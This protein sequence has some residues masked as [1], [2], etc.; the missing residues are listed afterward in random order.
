MRQ[1]I[2]WDS[3]PI[4]IGSIQHF[5]YHCFRGKKSGLFQFQEEKKAKYVYCEKWEIILSNFHVNLFH[6]YKN[7]DMRISLMSK[8]LRSVFQ[9]SAVGLYGSLPV[10]RGQVGRIPPGPCSLPGCA[11]SGMRARGKLEIQQME[12]TPF[13]SHPA[14][15]LAP[16]WDLRSVSHGQEQ[17]QPS[18]SAQ[19]RTEN[20]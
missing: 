5:T 2:P 1:Y 4:K 10:T 13:S 8:A 9:V 19:Q 14:M 12:L 20:M 15:A 11:L 7:R 6:Y 16:E 3:F 17:E 18:A